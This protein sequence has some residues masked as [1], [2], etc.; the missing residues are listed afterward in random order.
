MSWHL[1]RM[2]AFDTETTGIDRETDRIVTAAVILLGGDEPAETHTWLANPGIDIP[3]GATAIHGITTEHAREHGRP[4]V[5]VVAEV[6]TLLAKQI[7]NGV[8]LVVMNAT[9][10]LTLLDRELSRH[11]LP[12]LLEQA[13]LR[14]PDVIDPLVIDRGLDPYRP[15]K[16]RLTDLA[17]HYG[18]TLDDAHNAAADA[19]GA[20]RVAWMQAARTPS[21]QLGTAAIHLRQEHWAREWAANYQ[22]YLRSKG[23]SDAIVDGRWPMIPRQQDGGM[24]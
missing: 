16:R 13:N 19:I 12:S 8:P 11:Q 21:L 3:A 2:A 15:G 23:K 5:E 14:E 1:G 7:V 9:Y 22:Q 24:R 17:A 4:A 18:V 20:A 6:S 10:D